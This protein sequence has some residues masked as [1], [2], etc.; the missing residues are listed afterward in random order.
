MPQSLV[1]EAREEVTTLN[2]IERIDSGAGVGPRSHAVTVQT[3]DSGGRQDC[4]LGQKHAQLCAGRLSTHKTGQ[5]KRMK[6][7]TPG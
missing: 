1:E 5:I 7:K 3:W 6:I 2:S 4:W